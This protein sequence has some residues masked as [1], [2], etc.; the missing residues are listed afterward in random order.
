MGAKKWSDLTDGQKATVVV[1]GVAEAVMT[2]IAL[3]DLARRPAEDVRGPKALWALACFV[4]P[5]G[6][7]AYLAAGRR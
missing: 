2:A 5:L 4:Q 6:P 7:V 3:R 1:G